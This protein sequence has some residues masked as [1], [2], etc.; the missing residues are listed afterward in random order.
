MHL[1]WTCTIIL[2]GTLVRGLIKKGQ[3]SDF[4]GGEKKR[5]EGDISSAHFAECR[6]YPV[7]NI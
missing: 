5:S 6:T 3:Y 2:V 7:I 1:L 4:F